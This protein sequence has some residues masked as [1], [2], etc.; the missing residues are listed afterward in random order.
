[1][2]R[3]VT[4]DRIKVTVSSMPGS[5]ATIA[6]QEAERENVKLRPGAGEP[7]QV[8]HTQLE[9]GDVTVTRLFD[10]DTDAALLAKLNKGN[11]FAGTTITEQYLDADGNAVPGSQSH[12]HRVRGD[13]VLRPGGRRE[14][15]RHGLPDGDL[16]A[17]GGRVADE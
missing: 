13:V 6:G 17:C 3:F 10:A 4:Q 14:L 11:A 5:W 7:K 15:L 16:V 9:Y 8:V 1:M 2:S 12:P